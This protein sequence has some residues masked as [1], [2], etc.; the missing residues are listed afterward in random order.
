M[1][2]EIK[3]SG[4]QRAFRAYGIWW[5]I[6]NT[7]TI[8]A[9]LAVGFTVFSVALLAGRVEVLPF[10]DLV[11]SQFVEQVSLEKQSEIGIGVL[12]VTVSGTSAAALYLIRVGTARWAM[13]RRIGYIHG[14]FA[15]EIGLSCLESEFNYKRAAAIMGA[16]IN[17]A[18]NAFEQ[19]SETHPR[20]QVL[21]EKARMN[22]H[23]FVADLD[24]NNID[25]IEVA[26]ELYGA[27]LMCQKTVQLPS[28][29]RSL[30][31]RVKSSIL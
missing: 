5:D 12:S 19:I 24:S 7:A 1:F 10:Q 31:H 17:S 22:A 20:A 8:V 13:N 16:F 26:V 25:A 2:Y 9:I 14:Y 3:L 15:Q 29:L 28:A 23:V 4:L 21:F 6:I 30:G 27:A 18:Q 11:W